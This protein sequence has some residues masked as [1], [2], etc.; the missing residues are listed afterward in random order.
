V[1]VKIAGRQRK[2]MFSTDPVKVEVVVREVEREHKTTRYMAA[3]SFTVYDAVPDDV[4]RIVRAAIE[5]AVVDPQCG[6]EGCVKPASHAAVKE[7][8]GHG[9]HEG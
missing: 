7:E 4:Y 8:A 9:A 2:R 1:T 6:V 3:R 5:G